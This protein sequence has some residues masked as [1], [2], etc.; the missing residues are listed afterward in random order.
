MIIEIVAIEK[1][2]ILCVGVFSVYIGIPIYSP[3]FYF[4]TENQK[5]IIS[6]G[7]HSDQDPIGCAIY[8]NI[9]KMIN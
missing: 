4:L 5:E 9:I 8:N 1:K 3:R 7:L 2:C 6:Q